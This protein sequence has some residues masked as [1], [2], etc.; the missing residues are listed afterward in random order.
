MKLI[1]VHVVND[2][3]PKNIVFGFP[4]SPELPDT[5]H[6]LG[7]LDQRFALDWVQNNIA[8]FGGSPDKVTIFGESAGAFSA[9][10][11]LTSF[12]ANSNP[13][14]RGA[15]LESGQISYRTPATEDPLESWQELS[16]ALGCPGDYDSDLACVRAAPAPKIRTIIDKQMI[17]FNPIPDNVT[18]VSDPA[19][20]RLSGNIAHIPVMG[21]TNGQEGRVF[22]VGQNDTTA[23]LQG[24]FGNNTEF[25]QAIEAAYPLG[26]DGLN[27][28]YDQISQIYTEAFFQCG[29]AK[30]ANATAAVGIPAWRYYFNAS[31][32][33][34]QGYPELGVY[35]S[36]EIPM[37]FG[38]YLPENTTTQEYA[39]SKSMQGAWARFAK[40]PMGG[41][42]WNQVSTGTAGTVLVG[43]SDLEVGG[44]YMDSSGDM[45]S[46]AWDLGLFGN[47]YDAMSAGIT[48]IDEYEVDYRC[49]LF[50][51]IYG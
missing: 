4:S 49:S 15:I 19:G 43:A 2:A 47:R 20:R 1:P 10:A 7:F 6:N 3:D 11:L 33:N 41:P 16:D 29:Q 18:L 44:V 21:G 30:W 37:V 27:T 51:Q 23:F 31:F 32:V 38:A 46:G 45:T 12:P 48:V 39:L 13:P 40:N 14:F 34:T 42:G 5:G 9:D 26:Q 50:D 24:A 36:S 17:V 28:P 22:V 35:H 8:A 25:T